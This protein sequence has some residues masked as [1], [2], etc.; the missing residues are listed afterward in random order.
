MW[1]QMHACVR[2][3]PYLSRNVPNSPPAPPPKYKK[4]RDLLVFHIDDM[5]DLVEEIHKRGRVSKSEFRALVQEAVEGKP[6][7]T[8]EI[9]L[10]YR[11]FESNEGV[12]MEMSKKL[13][14]DQD[15][16]DFSNTYLQ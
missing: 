2:P 10:L 11:V 12:F 16:D 1:L 15:L 9:N 13:R 5:E 8:D 4:Y 14:R 7:S 3:C 6:M